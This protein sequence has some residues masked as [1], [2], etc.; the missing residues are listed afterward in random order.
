MIADGLAEI[1]EQSHLDQSTTRRRNIGQREGG[2][3]VVRA[4]HVGTE[5]L[6]A[7]AEP[8]GRI[9]S[10]VSMFEQLRGAQVGVLAAG[11]RQ[12]W[13]RPHEDYFAV[14]AERSLERLHDLA[15]DEMRVLPGVF[16]ERGEFVT[17]E[18]GDGVT[19]PHAAQ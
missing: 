14:R 6:Q 5:S 19:G 10:H 3:A 7:A 8:F 12:A 9:H 11:N 1:A 18:S 16:D 13:A 2:T 17:A 4:M 15:D